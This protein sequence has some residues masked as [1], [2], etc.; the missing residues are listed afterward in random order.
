LTDA[1]AD[2]TVLLTLAAARKMKAGTRAAATGEVSSSIH[3]NLTQNNL[4]KVI[5]QV[6]RMAP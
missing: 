3:C 1:T 2:L 5:I 4:N 6:E